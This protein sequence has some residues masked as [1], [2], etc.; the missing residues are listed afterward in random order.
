MFLNVFIPQCRKYKKKK[1]KRKYFFC[2]V[3]VVMTI[4]RET[5]NNVCG[6]KQIGFDVSQLLLEVSNTIKILAR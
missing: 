4:Q 6:I 3:A 5:D 2:F 1:R